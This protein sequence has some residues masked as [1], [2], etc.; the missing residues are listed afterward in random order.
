MMMIATAGVVVVGEITSR[1]ST[2]SAPTVS[3]PGAAETPISP[4]AL[5]VWLCMNGG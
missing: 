5:W 4:V 3:T 1:H 2:G